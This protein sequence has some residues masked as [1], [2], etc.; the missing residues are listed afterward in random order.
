LTY[1]AAHVWL[2]SDQQQQQQQQ[3]RGW[4]DSQH[5][6]HLQQ[7]QQQSQGSAGSDGS[8]VLAPTRQL[9]SHASYKTSPDYI[10]GLSGGGAVISSPRHG[11]VF[12]GKE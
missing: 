12:T 1:N 10:T 2:G 8:H 4:P 5:Q 9:S 3:Q 7:Q 6:F 11:Q